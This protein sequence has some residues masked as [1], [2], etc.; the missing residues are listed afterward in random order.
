MKRGW[1]KQSSAA[2]D[3]K[4]LLDSLMGPSRDVHKEETDVAEGFLDRKV[5]KR[6]LVGLCPN[7]WFKSTKREM[8]TCGK[9]HSDLLAEEMRRHPKAEKY[10]AEYEEQL[11]SYL[12]N[13]T[14]DTDRWVSRERGNLRPPSKELQ[15][16]AGW[17]KSFSEK[18]D[19][20]K[21]LMDQ[22]KKLEEAGE[23]GRCQEV[24]ENAQDI[25]AELDDIRTKFTVE[26]GGEAVCEACGVRYP[27]G[28]TPNEVGNRVSHFSGKMHEAYTT[29]RDKV[30]EL[31]KNKKEGKWDCL[32]GRLRERPDEDKDSDRRGDK[33]RGDKERG[34]KEKVDR[35]RGEKDKGEK[36]R[37][38]KE[39]GEKDKGEK[40][41]SDKDRGEKDRSEKDQ[42]KDRGR[43][44]SRSRSRKR[45]RSRDR[46]KREKKRSRSRSRRRKS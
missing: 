45:S 25:Q 29:I 39:K 42:S 32:R 40:D 43:K 12:D 11:L 6:Y 3:A 8:E 37:G 33:D 7:D 23:M 34:D 10:I 31:R 36:D 44:R 21:E 30:Q 20:Y 18:S 28:D 1:Q 41:R 13:I 22:V 35:D 14:Q 38:E 4:A 19:E 26:T 16:S 27:L 46:S 24:M 2:D 9:I 15:L 5:C 17:Q